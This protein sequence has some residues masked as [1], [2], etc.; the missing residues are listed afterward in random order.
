VRAA[1][2]M[3]FGKDYQEK[4]WQNPDARQFI[5][6]AAQ[7]STLYDYFLSYLNGW[8]SSNFKPLVK[9]LAIAHIT[10]GGIPSK[11]GDDILFPLG[12]SANL[13]ELWPPPTIMSLCA[14]WRGMAPYE[15][16]KTWHG[17]QGV[18]VVVRSL[19]EA[20]YLIEEAKIN[21]IEA[22]VCGSITQHSTPRL[23]IRSGFDYSMLEYV[24]KN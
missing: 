2:R 18:L 3:E 6:Q 9:M 5:L 15:S 11:F 7:P 1:F 20:D 21:R 16:Y 8:F 4:W 14:R 17:G 13:T 23:Y 12:L 24:P 22:K 10:G 19:A